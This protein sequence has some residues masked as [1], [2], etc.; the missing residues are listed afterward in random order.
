MVKYK[1]HSG[2]GLLENVGIVKFWFINGVPFTF[3]EL[4]DIN[5]TVDDIPE[6]QQAN[7]TYNM[8]DMYRHSS[9]LI[10]E[11]CHPI[12]FCIDDMIENY[13]DIPL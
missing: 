8:D 6:D 7:I 3:D 9:Y 1:I 12:L 11:G 2:F 10:E 13:Q 5:L 4:E